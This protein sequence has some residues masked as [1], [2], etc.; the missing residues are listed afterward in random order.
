MNKK[1][2]KTIPQRLRDLIVEF[3]FR[4]LDMISNSSG[5]LFK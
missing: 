2:K 5:L 4:P 1:K 3:S